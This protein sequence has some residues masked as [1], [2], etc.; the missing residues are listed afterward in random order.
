M[1]MSKLP[2]M[3]DTQRQQ[4]AHAAAVAQQQQPAQPPQ[5]VMYAPVQP[6]GAGP[7]AWFSIA[8]GAIVLL[9]NPRLWQFLLF[10]SSFTWTFNDAQGNPLAYPQTVFFW[11]DLAMVAYGIVLI[12]DGLVLAFARRPAALM[13]ALAL[14]VVATLLNLGYLIMM[15]SMNFGLQLMSALAVAFGVYIAMSQWR[16]LQLLRATRA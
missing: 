7:E 14:T 10:R 12:V 3:S 15:M 6:E 1:D 2:R 4:E 9:M 11:G 13:A 5:P 16:M 8:I